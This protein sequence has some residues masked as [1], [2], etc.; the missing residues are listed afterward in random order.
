VYKNQ[1][2]FKAGAWKQ[3]VGRWQTK[4]VPAPDKNRNQKNV[5]A[6]M[7]PDA[8]RIVSISNNGIF[9]VRD[10]ALIVWLREG[11]LGD[12]RSLQIVFDQ[13]FVAQ[14]SCSTGQMEC[15]LKARIGYYY[16]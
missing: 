9:M 13:F 8:R 4:P 11:S 7:V 15:V 6:K 5:S 14:D 12:L 2:C 1:T 16:C 10:W 3:K